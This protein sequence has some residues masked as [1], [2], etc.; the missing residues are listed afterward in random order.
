M[1]EEVPEGHA[2]VCSAPRTALGEAKA[3]LH[4]L[5]AIPKDAPGDLQE[6]QLAPSQHSKCHFLNFFPNDLWRASAFLF[7]VFQHNS[8]SLWGEQNTE[9]LFCATSQQR[10]PE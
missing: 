9:H 4:H 8:R 6:L 7:V 10:S 2:A 5:P 1:T 3:E